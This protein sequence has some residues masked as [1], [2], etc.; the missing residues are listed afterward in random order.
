[1]GELR[2][3]VASIPSYDGLYASVPGHRKRRVYRNRALLITGRTTLEFFV[4]K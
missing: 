2:A 1:M 4:R 3:A